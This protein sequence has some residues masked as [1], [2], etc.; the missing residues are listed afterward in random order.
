M[1]NFIGPV[2]CSTIKLV[3]SFSTVGLLGNVNCEIEVVAVPLAAVTVTV[4]VVSEAEVVLR[5]GGVEANDGE[6]ELYHSIHI[7]T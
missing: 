6:E 3:L 2:L 4:T 5:S 1:I 7:S